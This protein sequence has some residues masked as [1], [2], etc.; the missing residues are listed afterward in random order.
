MIKNRVLFFIATFLIT[1]FIFLTLAEKGYTGI[2]MIPPCPCDTGMTGE[3]SGNEIINTV[4]P[5][6][7]LGSDSGFTIDENGVSV[8]LENPP[9]LMYS[10]S[11][12][13]GEGSVC[14]L[15]SANN[16]GWL[17]ILN[18]EEFEQCN[19]RLIQGCDLL[20]AP[21]PPAQ[22]PTLSEWGL[23]AMAAIMGIVG[24]MVIRRRKITA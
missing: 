21:P 11:G 17:I 5:G 19:E 20:P 23:I 24:F 3:F 13:G 9:S 8:F 2:G 22:V 15:N 12:G 1:S 14:I 7:I 18:N 6:G 4:C 16:L 10:T